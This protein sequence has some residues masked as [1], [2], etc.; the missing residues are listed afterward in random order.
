MPKVN[1]GGKVYDTSQDA[2]SETVRRSRA[3]VGVSDQG[4]RGDP[5]PTGATGPTGPAG[6]A[7]TPGESGAT[8]PEGATGATGATGPSGAT[9]ST[10]PEGA[11]AYDAWLQAGNVGSVEDFVRTFTKNHY[12]HVQMTPETVWNIHHTLDRYA[13]VTVVDSGGTQVEGDV[14]Y[15]SRSEVT[16]AFSAPFAGEAFLN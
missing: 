14:Q 9:G 12:R 6:P 7:G 3:V 10:G 11:S 1:I 15:V 13:S 2:V 8:G 16:I 5:G 4:P